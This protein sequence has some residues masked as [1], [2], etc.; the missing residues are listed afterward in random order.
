MG[1]D[2]V[3]SAKDALPLVKPVLERL[4][5]NDASA[6]F[7]CVDEAT[8]GRRAAAEI[9]AELG[10]YETEWCMKALEESKGE[11]SGA[12]SWLNDHAPKAGETL[13]R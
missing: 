8:Q 6:L 9:L 1:A 13:A 4:D 3:L 11:I 2:R 7:L 10:E 5:R 12:Q